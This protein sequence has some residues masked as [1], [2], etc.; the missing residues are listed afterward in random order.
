VSI[1]RDHEPGNLEEPSIW[2]LEFRPDPF[3]HVVLLDAKQLQRD[4]FLTSLRRE[5]DQSSN[6]EALLF[7]HG[8]NVSF[9]DAAR[10][11]AQISYDLGFGGAAIMYNWP[12][13]TKVRAYV[14]DRAIATDQSPEHLA[15]FLR[16]LVNEVQP[17][18]LHIIAHSMGNEVLC[19]ALLTLNGSSATIPDHCLANVVLAAPDVFKTV[20]CDRFATSVVKFARHVTLYASSCDL[21]LCAS[22]ELHDGMARLGQSGDSITV[23]EGIDTIDA[24][25]LKEG[26]L[27]HAYFAEVRS[28]IIDLIAMILYD[29]AAV[30]RC[31]VSRTD[32]SGQRHWFFDPVRLR[33]CLDWVQQRLPGA[34]SPP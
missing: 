20:F 7:I 2:R 25:L 19:R 10:R 18:R 34:P 9:E 8:F 29:R 22:E 5:L 32:A 30:D 21:A 15:A 27:Y 1:P 11:T 16:L 24:D 4:W 31:L 28:V 14:A 12:S 26:V 33:P 17:R 3:E 23:V 13:H 6:Q